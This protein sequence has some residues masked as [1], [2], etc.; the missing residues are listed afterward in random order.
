[1]PEVEI[2]LL[3]GNSKAKIQG[4]KENLAAYP[5]L[6]LWD[7]RKA[8]DS[9]VAFEEVILRIAGRLPQSRSYFPHGCLGFFTLKMP[10]LGI[11]SSHLLKCRHFKDLLYGPGR[12]LKPKS[13]PIAVDRNS[14][15]L[16]GS[17][18][19]ERRSCRASGFFNHTG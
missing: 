19:N 5:S 9:Q 17:T 18:L 12:R 4:S 15:S 13:R 8:T 3:I 1:M 2:S 10:F 11:Y 6:S 16:P 14:N 7:S